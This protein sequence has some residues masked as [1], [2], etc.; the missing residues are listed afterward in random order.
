[1]PWRQLHSLLLM[2]NRKRRSGV[3]SIAVG[4]MLSALAIIIMELGALLEIADLTGAMLA[5]LVIWFLQIEFSTSIAAGAFFVVS[6]LSF[7]LLPSKLPSF[8]FILLYG[9]YPLLKYKCDSAPLYRSVKWL[10][11]VGAWIL[12]VTLEEIL[13]RSILG[14]VQNALI[15]GLIVIMTFLSYLLY[16]YMLTRIALIYRYKWRK[17]IF[18]S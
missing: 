12:A 2:K 17:H 16:D 3:F 4:A 8:Y 14:Y 9:W 11:K 5:S 1:M 13:A 15:T 7:L 10:I 18:K 6:L